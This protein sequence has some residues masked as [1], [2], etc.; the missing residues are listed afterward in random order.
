[1]Y[2][3]LDLLIVANLFREGFY[4]NLPIGGLVILALVFVHIPKP[5][6]QMT[7]PK[8]YR[9]TF[10]SLDPIGFI[11]FAPAAIMF[12]IA[13]EWGGV[14]YR[15]GSS[16]IIGLFC[17]AGGTFAIFLGWEYK[18]GDTAM[19]P[20]GLLKRRVVYSS[21]LSMFFISANLLTTS[22]YLSIYFQAVRG[23]KPLM[24]G[25]DV[26]PTIIAMLMLAVSSGILG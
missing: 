24:A 23:A 5:K 25:V 13:L 9:A 21:C 3:L 10:E 14:Q 22:Y 16:T 8:T 12:L 6:H 26:L 4:I 15:W 7:A 17:G 2:I 11:L 19:I 1:M 18:R 20:F